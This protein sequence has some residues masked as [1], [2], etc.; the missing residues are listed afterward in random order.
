M[1]LTLETLIQFMSN[2]SQEMY[3]FIGIVMLV[4]F[5][6]VHMYSLRQEKKKLSQAVST[7]VK[8]FKKAFD[9]A[10]DGMLILSDTYDVLYANNTMVNL[11]A[12][13]KDFQYKTFKYMPQI[14][15]AKNWVNL[16]V[17]LNAQKERMGDN[18]LPFP[19]SFFKSKG[20]RGINKP[21]S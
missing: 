1:D 13:E 14:K 15:T 5:F 3:I 19:Q 8:V 7:Q 6:I 9:T 18:I 11:L 10:T 21:I 17:F 16:D 20:R 4:T 2:I 12:L